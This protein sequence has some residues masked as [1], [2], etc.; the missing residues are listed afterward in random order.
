MVGRNGEALPRRILGTVL[1]P[2]IA[3]PPCL[4]AWRSGFTLTEEETKWLT[5]SPHQQETLFLTR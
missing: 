2:V 3:R 5:Y 1:Q 4:Q